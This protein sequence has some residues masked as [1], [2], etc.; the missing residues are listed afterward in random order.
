MS[1]L[2]EK[3]AK[4]T[5][6]LVKLKNE[7]TSELKVSFKDLFV[8]F[9]KKWEGKIACIYWTQYTP[10]FNDG[11]SCVFSLGDINASITDDEEHLEEIEYPYEG[12]F[13]IYY[14]SKETTLENTIRNNKDD[15]ITLINHFGSIEKLLECHTEFEEIIKGVNAIPN[16][17]LEEVLGDHVQ[18]N[19]TKD[20][21]DI[22]EY[23]HD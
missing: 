19:I 8:P 2:A 21:I 7:F 18:V 11:D 3:I 16:D 13:P 1:D 5:E 4:Q 14:Y 20:G 23:D 12:D 9:M 17:V 15:H 22:E 10:Y 6:Q